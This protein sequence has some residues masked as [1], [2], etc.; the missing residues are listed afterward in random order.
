MSTN[1]K[2]IDYVV[3][4]LIFNIVYNIIAIIM[5]FVLRTVTIRYL[6]S[7]YLGLNSLC[8]SV[9]SVLSVAELG[10]TSA[11]V[12]RLYKPL[13]TRDEKKICKLLSYYRKVYHMIGVIILIG[14]GLILP[15]LKDFISGD[16][17]VGI[18]IYI[19]Y[20]L[21][22]LNTVVSYLFG[23][24]QEILLIAQERYDYIYFF[25]LV[26]STILYIGQIILVI[27][28]Y[29]YL[30]VVMLP[31]AML[32]RRGMCYYVI[33]TRYSIYLH[34]E[35]IEPRV[36]NE[37]KKEVMAVAVYKIRDVSMNS[38]DSVVVSTFV[39]LVALADYQNYFTV[40][41]VPELI[42]GQIS[43]V[44]APSLGNFAASEG[45]E[46][47][48]KVYQK[49]TFFHMF[50]SGWF[51]I[52]YGYLIQDFIAIW[53]GRDYLMSVK[54]VILFS[55]NIYLY[56][57][58][59][60]TKMIRE[61]VGLFQYGKVWAIVEIFLN[62]LLNIILVYFTGAEGVIL[63]TVLVV[64]FIMIPVEDYIVYKY[65]FKGKW[66]QRLQMAIGNFIWVGLSAFTVFIMGQLNLCT[67][68]IYTFIYKILICAL[69]P[70]FIL[71]LMFHK[72]EELQFFIGILKGI[73]RKIIC[74]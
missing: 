45:I 40:F 30:S 18:N 29:Y 20:I 12:Y 54:A 68:L 28:K 22:L 60:L 49:N 6:G 74:K 57:E 48:F 39:G 47:T 51:A 32:I 55:I 64:L 21:Y 35:S 44:I 26:S 33:K 27:F 1:H 5:P 9:L 50:L 43:T 69:L 37:I 34:R 25:T 62:L 56:G 70:P 31:V 13:A 65:Y 17:P 11:F 4:N 41:Q 38:F 36:R 16:T 66:K 73:I 59:L 2:R 14:G 71:I 61:N 7:E 24:Y 23:A 67:G 42:L 53:L 19:V 46:D 52:C 8:V 3:R 63:A 72:T 15:F 10:M 58:R